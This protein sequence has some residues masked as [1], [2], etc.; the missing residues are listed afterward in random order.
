MQ[1]K[2]QSGMKQGNFGQ[3]GSFWDKIP[4]WLNLAKTRQNTQRSE[5]MDKPLK[6]GAT[7]FEKA[8]GD[9]KRLIEEARK[10]LE[11]VEFDT[12]VGIGLSGSLVIPIL[13]RAFGANFAIVRKE[14]SSHDD[15][16]VVGHIGH[17][18]IFVDDF[19]STGTSREKVISAISE[20]TQRISKWDE[21]T[22]SYTYKKF[23]TKY[24]GTYEYKYASFMPDQNY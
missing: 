20:I 2:P 21:S 3:F 22:Q 16:A 13:A 14:R 1:Q 5:K 4:N 24:V 9:E 12:M 23:D 19:I 7:Y 11:N 10:A 15:S 6:V 17:K 8:F 18:W